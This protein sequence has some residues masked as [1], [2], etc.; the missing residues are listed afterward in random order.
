MDSN[1]WTL[2]RTASLETPAMLF[3][4]ACKLPVMGLAPASPENAHIHTST[5]VRSAF[6]SSRHVE[7]GAQA[8]TGWVECFFGTELRQEFLLFASERRFKVLLSH[9]TATGRLLCGF[10]EFML[11]ACCGALKELRVR[12]A[13]LL[14]GCVAGGGQ[15][16]HDVCVELRADFETVPQLE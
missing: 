3:S 4:S 13:C 11:R 2:R 9:Q 5:H 15:F 10:L 14:D 6:L 8:L 1:V 12:L 7:V 16:V